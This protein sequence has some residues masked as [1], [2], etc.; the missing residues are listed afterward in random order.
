MRHPRVTRIHDDAHT[1]DRQ[2]GFGNRRGQHHAPL[3]AWLDCTILGFPR[4]IAVERMHLDCR[5]A[6]GCASVA[7][8]RMPEA[9]A[10]QCT[11]QKFLGAANLPCTRQKHQRVAFIFFQGIL[12]GIGNHRRQRAFRVAARITQVHRETPAFAYDHRG[13]PEQLRHCGAVQRRGHHKDFQIR[14]QVAPAVERQRQRQVGVQVALMKF[15]EDHQPHAVER[16][17]GLQPARENTLG[18]HLDAR[19]FR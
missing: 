18:Q 17:I 5:A 13:I 9:T 6:Q 14:P 1:L 4:Q 7:K 11:F 10:A 3:F 16:G 2:A 19:C 12:H 8:G 15:V